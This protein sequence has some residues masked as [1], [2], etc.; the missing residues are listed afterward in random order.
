MQ[1]GEDL[2]GKRDTDVTTKAF[3]YFNLHKKLFSVRDA[4]SRLVVAHADEATVEDAVFSVSQAGRERV[5][6]E[7]SKNVHAGVR[8]T[9]SLRGGPVRGWTRVTYNPYKYRTFVRASD[10]AP[11]AGAREVRLRLE[12]GKAR[13]YARGLVLEQ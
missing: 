13:M 11:L 10:E 4:R 5:L 2:P 8:G 12:N 3:I 7:R 1:R 9:A 6:R